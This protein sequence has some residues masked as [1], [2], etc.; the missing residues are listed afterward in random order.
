MENNLHIA[1]ERPGL[2]RVV[3][4]GNRRAGVPV[5]RFF[6]RFSS[7]SD[8]PADDLDFLAERLRLA[9]EIGQGSQTAALYAAARDEI[10]SRESAR[11]D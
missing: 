3:A 2:P 11:N 9:M 8:V 5:K 1:G 10:R 7:L 6:A 4:S